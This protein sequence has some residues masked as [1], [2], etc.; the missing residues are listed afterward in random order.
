MSNAKK[1]PKQQTSPKTSPKKSVLASPQVIIPIA[2]ILCCIIALAVFFAGSSDK[3]SDSDVSN[4]GESAYELDSSLTYYADI[5]I[6]DY[7]TITVKLDQ[8][9][10]P[11]ST[12]NFVKL[13]ESGFYDG[14]TFHR[15]IENFM[16]QGGAPKSDGSS[17]TPAKIVGE[18]PNNGYDNQ[19]SHTRGAISMARAKDY[20]SGSSQFF[21]VHEDSTYLDG[22]YA[23]FGYV[24]EGI[25]VVDQV[26]ESAQPTD[27][28][29]TIAADQQPI[30]TSV[31]IRTE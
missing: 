31:K 2:V 10:A 24:T 5:E 11:I 27:G 14:L 9:S 1:K 28:N 18:F 16:M 13:A 26:C 4:T 15:I 20:N 22:D 12:A 6:K 7:G 21:I 23:V 17:G 19:L 8:E 29:G 25:E 30:M 3:D